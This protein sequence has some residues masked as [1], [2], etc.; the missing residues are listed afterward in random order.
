MTAATKIDW[1]LVGNEGVRYPIQS[2]KRSL[3]KAHMQHYAM[4]GLGFR[5]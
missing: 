3:A 5:V 2:L 4:K 1:F